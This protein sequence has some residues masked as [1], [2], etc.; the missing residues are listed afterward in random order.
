MFGQLDL[1]ATEI[2]QGQVGH[3]PLGCLFGGHRPS[4]SVICR[5]DVGSSAA[6]GSGF[7]APRLQEYGSRAR[8][9]DNGCLRTTP[10][11]S[12]PQIPVCA[13]TRPEATACCSAS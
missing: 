11:F 7:T 12:D 4:S 3:L 10:S 9:D 13:V 5:G 2:G 6:S 1:P 8:A